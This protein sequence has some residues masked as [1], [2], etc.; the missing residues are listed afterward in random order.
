MPSVRAARCWG[1]G[2]PLMAVYHDTEWGVPLFDDRKLFEFLVLE[3]MQAGLS[4]RTVLNKREH[5]RRAFDGFDPKRVAAY[6]APKIR[7]LLG[8]AGIIRNRQKIDAAVT[9]AREFLQVQ[10]EFGSFHRFMWELVDGK[11]IVNAWRTI[12][13]LP[14]TSPE[15]DGMSRALRERGF[16]FVGSTICYAHM[17][18][19][20]MVNDHLVHC[21]RYRQCCVPSTERRRHARVAA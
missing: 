10:K 3:G 15:S 7:Q 6:R 2:D 11:P 1:D 12:R 19:T 20:G 9:N 13:E 18:A 4:W 8:N 16:R 21:F 14:A 5:F 17:Q